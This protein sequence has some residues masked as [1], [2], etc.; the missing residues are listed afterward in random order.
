MQN[1]KELRERLARSVGG[2]AAFAQSFSVRTM[3]DL[4]DRAAAELND[5][6]VKGIEVIETI[7]KALER[8]GFIRQAEADDE[9]FLNRYVLAWAAYQLAGGRT[10]NAMVTGPA[11]FPVDRNRKRLDTE[12]RRLGEL[13]DMCAQA[14]GRAVKAAQ[15]AHKQSLGAGGVADAELEDLR[16]RLAKREAAQDRMK[17]TNAIIRKG[18]YEE[19]HAPQ[20]AA[21][22]AA[23]GYSIS[24]SLAGTIL[25]RP[26]P[27][28]PGGYQAYQLTNNLSEIKRLKV[29]VAE[30]GAKAARIEAAAEAH[31]L[32]RIVH[33]VELIEDAADDRLRLIF[34]GKPAADMIARLKSRGF[35]W[36]PRAGAWQRQL[37]ANARAAAEAILAH[38]PAA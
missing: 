35:R 12:Q 36:S 17:A 3:R 5:G 26:Y 29:R 25:K 8:A 15:R 10:A 4:K 38:E 14:P 22:M 1:A 32:S 27:S 31:P 20:F 16:E 21:D 33:G 9:A 19:S 28:C 34:D 18:K 11:N 2:E 24:V 7:G 37:T 23:A 6:A 30:V 13:C